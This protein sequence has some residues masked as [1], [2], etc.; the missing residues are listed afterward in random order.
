MTQP[1]TVLAPGFADPSHDAQR[2]FRA[3]LDAFAHP[4]RITSLPDPLAGPGTS[5]RRQRA[6]S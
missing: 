4:G 6:T 3:V 2:L 5:R 1:V